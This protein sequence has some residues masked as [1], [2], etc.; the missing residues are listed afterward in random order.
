MKRPAKY[1]NR[2]TV[3]GDLTFDSAKEAKRWGE[4]QLLERAGAITELTRQV[5]YALMVNGVKVGALVADFA[6]RENGL[7]V[8]EDTKSE[9][10]RKLPVWRLKS[11]MFSAQYGFPVREV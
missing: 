9:F 4:L 6:Y 10:T 7:E 2:K 3:V 5:R 1:G 8:V 11:K